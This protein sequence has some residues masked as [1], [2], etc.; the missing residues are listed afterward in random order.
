MNLAD[1]SL[2]LV[3]LALR[4][5]FGFVDL[6]PEL[7]N[8]WRKW[9]SVKGAP[10]ALLDEIM[11]RMEAVNRAIAQAR[12]LGEQF[13][14]GHSYV[15]PSEAPGAGDEAAWLGWWRS[16]VRDEVRPLLAEYWYEE[17]DTARQLSD[18]LLTGL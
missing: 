4:R 14:I 17:P 13:R 11:A 16:V 2:A 18:Q 6:Q 5:R 1:R 9:C 8:G 3:D 12:G 15:T 7:G 10:D